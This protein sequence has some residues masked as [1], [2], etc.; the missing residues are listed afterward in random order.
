MMGWKSKSKVHFGRKQKRLVSF[1][2]VLNTTY[3]LS[4]FIE[5]LYE[6][7]LLSAAANC[8]QFIRLILFLA[9]GWLGFFIDLVPRKILLVEI[10]RT[11]CASLATFFRK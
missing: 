1:C 5:G 4:Y 2:G 11:A 8:L 7:K 3:E 6:Q 9:T 10:F